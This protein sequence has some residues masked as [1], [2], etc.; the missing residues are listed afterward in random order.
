MRNFGACCG[1]GGRAHARL[2]R[3]K[4]TLDAPHDA[5]AGE[6]AENGLE[7]KCADEYCLEHC[8]DVGN[9]H[10]E[11][12]ER[13]DYIQY[14]HDGD[15]NA[16]DLRKTQAAAEY[17]CAEQNGEDAADYVRS[18]FGIIEAKA[19]EGRLS[20]IRSEHIVAHSIGEDENYRKDNAEPALLEAVLHIVRRSTVARA[21]FVLALIDLRKRGLDERGSAAEDGGYPHPEDCT[22][23]AEDERRGNADDVARADTGCG[24]DHERT[25][26]GYA[27]LL[28]G[29]F[30]DDLYRLAEQAY[31]QKSRADGEVHTRNEQEQRHNVR[32]V[33]YTTDGVYNAVNFFYHVIL[34]F[35]VVF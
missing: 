12:H 30:A 10:D 27:T 34:S 23:A 18:G 5:R 35:F 3:V 16:G 6:A 15:E 11:Y 22:R 32:L 33:Q 28:L 21:V 9:I 7:I 19:A 17:A 13:D 31:L 4:A 20:I 14:A 24:G 8:G 25:E 1:I 2:I 29:F 26:R